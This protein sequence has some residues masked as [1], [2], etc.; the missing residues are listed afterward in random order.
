MTYLELWV[1]DSSFNTGGYENQRYDELI[2]QAKSE[3]DLGNRMDL[4]IEAER[5][6]IDEDAALAP[7]QF[8]GTTRLI[9]P[10]INNF[11]YHNLGGS[12]DLKLYSLQG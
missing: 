7:L 11:V 1:S 9:N 6:L 10:S 3:T 2:S 5:L 4:M 8:E 12:L